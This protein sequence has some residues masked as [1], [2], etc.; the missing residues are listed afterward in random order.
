M[1]KNYPLPLIL[2]PKTD[3]VNM[4]LGDCLINQLY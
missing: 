2:P 1:N 3:I 4:S